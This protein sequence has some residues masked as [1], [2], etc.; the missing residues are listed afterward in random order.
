MTSLYACHLIGYGQCATWLR[1]VFH[2][3]FLWD[4]VCS[5]V[6]VITPTV[7]YWLG[8][9]CDKMV[10]TILTTID[11]NVFY[12]RRDWREKNR[13]WKDD[14]KG[15]GE[16]EATLIPLVTA[17]SRLFCFS[18]S[19]QTSQSTLLSDCWNGKITAMP[20]FP[21]RVCCSNSLLPLELPSNVQINK[22]NTISCS[23]VCVFFSGS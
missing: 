14:R 3:L 2:W 6:D 22:R 9:R 1:P 7:W 18:L 15:T 20:F 8:P 17:V 10:C 16:K 13:P 4:T 23:W 19:A 12:A 11:T 5:L 21:Y